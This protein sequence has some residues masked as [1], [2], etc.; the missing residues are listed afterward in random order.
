MPQHPRLPFTPA[1]TDPLIH[2]GITPELSPSLN[3]NSVERGVG[4][5]SGDKIGEIGHKWL[6]QFGKDFHNGCGK[7][8]EK[9]TFLGYKFL[10]NLDF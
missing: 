9:P 8:C 10:K 6:T 5:I 2:E 3:D 7:P 1:E 4:S